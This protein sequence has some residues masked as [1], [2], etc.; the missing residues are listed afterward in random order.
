MLFSLLP[1]VATWQ[2]SWR[3][4][5]EREGTNKGDS[6]S[7]TVTRQRRQNT[8]IWQ[9]LLEDLD[10]KVKMELASKSL[11]SKL[12]CCGELLV[13]GAKDKAGNKHHSRV[14]DAMSVA[15]EEL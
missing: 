13:N 6:P 14:R 12:L 4:V 3:S 9:S 7:A 15:G 5:R 10:L 11:P 8:N 1:L 2:S